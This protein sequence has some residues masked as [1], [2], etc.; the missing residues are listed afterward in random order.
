MK[1]LESLKIES[2]QSRGDLCSGRVLFIDQPPI[3]DM[4][5]SRAYEGFRQMQFETDLT[6]K[7]IMILDAPV[8]HMMGKIGKLEMRELRRHL[9]G[10]TCI[11]GDILAMRAVFKIMRIQLSED[12]TYPSVLRQYMGRRL[13]HMELMK[14]L[15]WIKENGPMYIKPTVPKLF[16][17]QYVQPDSVTSVAE[18]FMHLE[19]TR[20]W[21]SEK[22]NFIAEYRCFVRHNKL[23]DIRHYSFKSM[24]GIYQDF[25]IS[26]MGLKTIHRMIRDWRDYGPAPEA[27]VMD[28]GVTDQGNLVLIECNEAYAFGSY[29]L[30]SQIYAQMLLDRYQEIKIKGMQK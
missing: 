14:A 11:V 8:Q 13:I 19:G 18:S 3:G 6:W 22:L 27:Y 20:C 4:D 17:V 10:Y 23:Q 29:G 2:Y 7:R 5:T 15:S 1:L 25:P 9:L 24:K 28:V 21:M 12:V 30:D 26:E 16:P